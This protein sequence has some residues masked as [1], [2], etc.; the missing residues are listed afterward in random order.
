MLVYGD[1][2]TTKD[3]AALQASILNS[4]AS[5]ATAPPGLD[6][7]ARLVSAFIEAG[8]LVCA[9]IDRDG[10]DDLGMP[11]LTALARCVDI[12]ST[13][14]FAVMGDLDAA[15]ALLRAMPASGTIR[16][17]PAEGYAFYALY[18]ESYAEAA[19]R[20]GLP[21]GT[22]VIGIRSIGTS[23]A[24]MVAAGLGADPPVTVRPVGHPFDRH[25][26]LDAQ[27]LVGDPP[28]FAVV[29][30][31]PGLSGSSF[32]AVIDWLTAHGVPPE[33]IHLFPSHSHGPG[34][35]A[36][37]HRRH[38]WQAAPKHVVGFE[39]AILGGPL[40]AWV[41]SI[42]GPLRAPL[43]DLSGGAW[44]ELVSHDAPAAP[45]WERRKYLAETAGGRWLV[46][47]AGLG[48]LAEHKLTLAHRLH[49]AGYGA[50]PAGLVHGLLVQRWLDCPNLLDAPLASDP[51]LRQLAAYLAFR[52]SLTA[53]LDAGASPAKLVEMAIY[54]T[55]QTLGGEVA[56]TLAQRLA[57]APQEPPNR[58]HVDARLHRWEWL[59]DGDR[60]LKTDALDHAM[61][62][63]F[64]GAQ[65]IEWDLAG[66]IVEHDLDPT[67][68]LAAFAGASGRSVDVDRLDFY[69]PCYLA[70]QLGAWTMSS[71][72]DAPETRRYRNRLRRL[73]SC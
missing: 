40:Q 4:V 63:D 23:L 24:A 9:L 25:V 69:L 67:R 58:V 56:A 34:A 73:L 39:D 32:G 55:T 5:L 65:P 49:A 45:S 51:L 18:P 35:Q 62:H 15:A 16:T 17:K 44:R 7:H 41:E 12:S 27:I 37:E 64:I 3:A 54:N 60:L 13:S 61:A 57:A 38:M 66:A 30:E 26:A 22:R 28:A 70:F 33:A 36:T 20:S 68:L 11:A 21:P 10:P 6:R 42:V 72:G 19:R 8:D 2:E 52:A 59:V 47:Y 53:P 14:N 48:P 43:R 29:D 1:V 31:G 71:G 50:E 46:K